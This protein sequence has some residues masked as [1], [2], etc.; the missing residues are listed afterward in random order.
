MEKGAPPA[1][2][3]NFDPI[4]PRGPQGKCLNER[5]AITEPYAMPVGTQTQIQAFLSLG[6]KFFITSCRVATVGDRRYQSL[7]QLS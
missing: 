1:Q 3:I 6:G 2:G 7:L 5:L 4:S